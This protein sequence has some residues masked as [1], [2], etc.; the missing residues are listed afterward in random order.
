MV[1]RRTT[2]FLK[3]SCL[4]LQIQWWKK[5]FLV[6]SEVFIK[7]PHREVR[8]WDDLWLP[9]PLP[10]SHMEILQG[11]QRC[12]LEHSWKEGWEIILWDW[13]KLSDLFSFKRPEKDADFWK[14]YKVTYNNMPFKGFKEGRNKLLDKD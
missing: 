11:M 5:M 12:C 1:V 2:D 8:S 9:N 7:R 4:I 14:K 6:V 3:K 10:L 13:I